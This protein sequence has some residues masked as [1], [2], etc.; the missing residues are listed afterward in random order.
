M[1]SATQIEI[2]SSKAKLL[3]AVA[4]S[5]DITF[6]RIYGN[7]GDHLIYAGARRLLSGFRYKE[8]SILDLSGAGGD[9]AII[10]GGGAWCGPYHDMPKHLPVVEQKFRRVVVLPSSFDITAP[11]VRDALAKTKATVFARERVSYEQIRDLC[12]ADLAHDCAFFFDYSPYYRDGHGRLN[13]YRLDAEALPGKIPEDNI[14]ISASCE[15]LDEWLWTIS[16]HGRVYTDRAHV[17]IAAAMLGKEVFYRASSYHKVPAIA[18]YAL[19]SLPVTREG[20]VDTEWLRERLRHEATV[21]LAA[22]PEGFLTRPREVEITIVML[23]YH[24]L[25]QTVNALKALKENVAVPFKLLLVD[26]N[27]GR[28]TQAR[29]K[30]V[31][32]EYDFVELALLDENLGCAGGRAYAAARAR[33]KYVLLLDN[34]IEVFPG[35]VEHLLRCLEANPETIA[36]TGRVIFPDGRMHLC[37]GGY[38][39]ENGLLNYE[40]FGFGTDYDNWEGASGLCQWVPGCLTLLRREALVEN[41]YDLGMRNYYEDLEWCYRLNKSG[42]GN[43]RRVTESVALHFHET[44][45]LKKGWSTKE[46]RKSSMRYVETIAYFYKIHGLVIPNL[47]H[48][49]PDLGVPLIQ[50][51]RLAARLFLDLVL[52]NGSEWVL[53]KWNRGELAPLFSNSKTAAED[54]EIEEAPA[55]PEGKAPQ[56]NPDIQ[57]KQAIRIAELERDLLEI[58]HSRHWKFFDRYWKFRRSVLSLFPRGKSFFLLPLA[59]LCPETV[60]RISA[61]ILNLTGANG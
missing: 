60:E 22:L 5:T 24:R 50:S 58:Y 17:M 6:I 31:C 12:E 43:F 29:L 52:A 18:E 48:Y 3:S 56:A 61:A 1:L 2:E 32:A 8:I 19:R 36:A 30:E 59:A 13:A 23:S 49:V 21:S 26:N 28:E 9:L 14:D 54:M 27:S 10:A 57:K 16:R 44:K 39:T 53:E 38:R 25:E 47:F 35:S 33:T 34:D 46:W 15:T 7:V 51:S 40:L 37:G 41:P 20:E 11:G 42:K 4:G 45:D 55:D